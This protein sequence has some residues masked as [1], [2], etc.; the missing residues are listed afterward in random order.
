VRGIRNILKYLGMIE[1]DLDLPSRQLVFE[2]APH[3]R[4]STSGYLV[5]RFDPD[6]LFLGEESGVPVKAG[7]VLG[8]V[9]DPYTF[10][11]LETL[12]APVDGILY[13][14][15]RS[16]PVRAGGHAYSIADLQQSR[17]IE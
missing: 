13:I 8:T 17:W 7:E 5:S 1:G 12:Q 4:P 9:F 16:G 2:V 15:R 10:D 3:I 14:A 11:D 6:Q